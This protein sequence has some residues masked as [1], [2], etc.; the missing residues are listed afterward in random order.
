MGENFYSK[1]FKKPLGKQE[2]WILKHKLIYYNVE[3]Q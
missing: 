2:K 1:I 3:L